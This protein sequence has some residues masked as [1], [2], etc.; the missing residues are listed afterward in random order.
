[1]PDGAALTERRAELSLLLANALI[2]TGQLGE[3]REI[4][5]SLVAGDSTLRYR[6]VELLAV[7][8][9]AVGQLAEA[10]ALLGA[11]LVQA[12]VDGSDA[13]A[14]L[15]VEFAATEMLQ[16][17]WRAGAERASQAVAL[18]GTGTRPGIPA[19]ATTLLALSELYQCR[20]SRGYALLEEARLGVDALT[21]VQLRD[22][23]GMVAALAWAE[24]LVDQH[25][26]ALRHVERGLRMA[27][28]YGR[29]AHEVSQLYLVRSIVHARTGQAALALADVE[30][31]EETAQHI[32]SPELRAFTLALKS[33]PLL[34]QQGA[35]A[36]LPIL[37]ELRQQRSI[38]SAWWRGI[39][40]QHHAEVLYFVNQI[41]ACR[42]LLAERVSAE[43]AGLGPYA[44]S[45][46]ALRSQ[47]EVACGDL[48][49]GWE[50]YERA[51][52]VAE[53]G[54]PPAQFGCVA[55]NQAVLYAAEG[56]YAQARAAGMNAVEQFEAVRL[57]LG[58]GLARTVV[59]DILARS[60]DQA[61]ARDQLGR[62]REAFD[63]CGAP[64]L[65][66]W[67]GREQRRTGARQPRE[68][69]RD[70]LSGREREIAELVA[71]GLTSPQIAGQLFLSPRTVE[72]HLNRIFAKLGVSSRAAVARM[73]TAESTAGQ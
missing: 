17:N 7:T 29:T 35:D 33:R 55:R 22:D 72:S 39:A 23:L 25:H 27:R 24:F 67:V 11:A 49:A 38:R 52:A 61:A 46:Y 4:L 40:D 51:V 69:D 44:P 57:P 31:G 16:G 15:L 20:F 65:S 45:V 59:A 9:R 37:A 71:Q 10:R 68:A 58:E 48:A 66:N 5:H 63:G 70:R 32:D 13:R 54:A 30:D 64:W 21:D 42:D 26:D 19:A 36:A 53:T 62:A 41:G 73:V 12:D 8:E 56:R 50:W 60:G 34:W 14:G 28:S 2:R 18:A 1:M 47:A 43:P 6:A 3:T